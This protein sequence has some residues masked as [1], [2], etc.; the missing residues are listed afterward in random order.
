MQHCTDWLWE[1]DGIITPPHSILFSQIL[2]QNSLP[3]QLLCKLTWVATY[4][5]RV[6]SPACHLRCCYGNVMAVGLPEEM[7]EWLLTNGACWRFKTPSMTSSGNI[8]VL[9]TTSCCS[10]VW[11]VGGHQLQFKVRAL[12]KMSELL[13]LCEGYP[14]ATGGIPP[15]RPVTWSFYVFFDVHMKKWLWKQ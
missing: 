10:S 1:I 12:K 15:Q 9:L 5:W 3:N 6:K 2:V 8:P 14:P 11:T 13:A 4:R 7:S